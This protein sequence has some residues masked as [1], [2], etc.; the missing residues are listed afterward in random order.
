MRAGQINSL[1]C[2]GVILLLSLQMAS[3]LVIPLELLRKATWMRCVRNYCG[4]ITNKKSMLHLTGRQLAK[5]S[6]SS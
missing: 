1:I 3:R 4:G 5:L 6:M 2:G